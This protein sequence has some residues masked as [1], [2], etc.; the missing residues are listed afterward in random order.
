MIIITY[1]ALEGYKHK[2][3]VIQTV[4]HCLACQIRGQGLYTGI[5]LYLDSE[6]MDSG[7]DFYCAFPVFQQ[8]NM[9]KIMNSP[10]IEVISVV[11]IVKF[12]TA[13]GIKHKMS[14]F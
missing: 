2:R 5:L 7:C 12:I 10:V 1:P 9:C 13:A 3:I 6:L 14:S 8:N 11:I 4:K